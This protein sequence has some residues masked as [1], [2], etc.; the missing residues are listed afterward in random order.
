MFFKW[1]ISHVSGDEDNILESVPHGMNHLNIT[2]NGDQDE[3]LDVTYNSKG[4]I[5]QKRTKGNANATTAP[6]YKNNQA[7]G[8]HKFSI[9]EKEKQKPKRM[10]NQEEIQCSVGQFIDVASV[11]PDLVLKPSPAQEG[12]SGKEGGSNEKPGIP[13]IPDTSLNIVDGVAALPRIIIYRKPVIHTVPIPQVRLS[14][15]L[16]WLNF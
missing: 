11:L 14:I 15:R 13:T 12:T 6:Y 8:N 5:V 4:P 9:I 2:K 7:N 1:Y 16:F 3:G 10:A